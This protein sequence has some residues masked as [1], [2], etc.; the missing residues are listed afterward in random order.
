[1]ELSEQDYLDTIIAFDYGDVRIGVA[2]KAAEDSSV[3]PLLTL[4]ND[5]ELWKT[6]EDLLNLHQPD[7]IVIG[8]PRNLEGEST[9]QTKLAEKFAT[10]LAKLYNNKIEL[11]DEALTTEQ[12]KSRIPKSLAR[13]SREVIDQYAACIIL[14]T[15]LKE[16]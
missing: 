14:E 15:Y 16:K 13:K 7:L 6:V 3:E 2:V 8:R 12:A 10:K 5:S 1:M 4:Q 11:V 9:A